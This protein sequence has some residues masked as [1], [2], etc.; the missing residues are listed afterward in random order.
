MNGSLECFTNL[1]AFAS[2]AVLPLAANWD[3]N[4]KPTIKEA[5]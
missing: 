3:V 2:T 4:T 1:I 5:F